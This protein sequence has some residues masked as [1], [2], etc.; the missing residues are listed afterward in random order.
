MASTAKPT[1]PDR[2][3][4]DDALRTLAWAEEIKKQPKLMEHIRTA[5]A[6]LKRVAGR[7]PGKGKK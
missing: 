2:L 7:A 3:E 1:S 4:I 5:A 6:D